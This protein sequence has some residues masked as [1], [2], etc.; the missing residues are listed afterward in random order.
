MAIDPICG[1]Q[2]DP[3]VAK[4]RYETPAGPVFFCSQGCLNRFREQQLGGQAEVAS[5]EV[6]LTKSCC[7]A[8]ADSAAEGTALPRGKPFPSLAV[9]QPTTPPPKAAPKTT[10]RFFCPCCPGVESKVPADCPKCGMPLQ[11]NPGYRE[12]TL[13]TCPMHPEIRR[14]EP[15]DCPICG[16]E[17][18][19]LTASVADTDSMGLRAMQRRFVGAA[20]GT[21]PL[22]VLA[23]GPMLGLSLGGLEHG[24]IGGWLQALLATPVVLWAGWPLWVRGWRSIVLGSPNMFTLIL[25]GTAAAFGLSWLVLLVPQWLPAAASGPHGSLYFE[26]A[27]VIVTLVLLGQVLEI[28]ARRRVQAAVGELLSLRPETARRLE[29][30]SEVEVPVERLRVGDRIRVL[31]GARIPTD[32]RVL[33][34][35]SFVDESMVTGEP[36][37]VRREPGMSVVGGT[38]NGDGP[39][40]LEV[41][42]ISTRSLLARIAAA[43]SEAQRTRAPIQSLADQVAGVFVPVVVAIALL[44]FLVWVLVGPPEM[45]W[46]GGFLAAVSVLLIACPCALGLATPVSIMVGMGRGARDGILIRDGETLERLAAVDVVAFDKTGTLTLGK[47]HL[48]AT[49]EVPSESGEALVA[50]ARLRQVA[51]AIESGS[52]HPLARAF[53]EGARSE[54]VVLPTASEIGIVPGQGVRGKV[55]GQLW[56]LGR[57]EW[58][59]GHGMVLP[60]ALREPMA[61]ATGSLVLLACDG[62]I[63]GGFEVGDE[64]K[65]ASAEA[66]SELKRMGIEPVL[67]T[68]DRRASA[69]RIARAVGIERVFAEVDPEGKL[70]E[71]RSLKEAGRKVAMIG[72]GINDAPALAAADVGIAMGTGTDVAIESAG[73]SLI[74][75]DPRSVARAIRISRRVMT[76]IRQNLFFAFVYNAA[77]IPIAAGVLYPWFGMLLSPMWAAAAMSFSSLSVIGNALRLRR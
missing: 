52:E 50:E 26:S 12:A 57:P 14:D 23:M 40:I 59:T 21:V 32:S 47:P 76:N 68:G 73:V 10:A 34:G 48:E 56:E 27:A 6:P 65:P 51:A 62:K 8:G 13:Y 41:R 63:V 66:V 58:L 44:A 46:T 16:M 74:A 4:W 24:A 36:L 72:D 75:G 61:R 77:G 29:G 19:P 37:P 18:E 43:V 60:E 28:V 25:L 39:L 5:P 17:L 53:V 69:E 64:L 38:L 54:H 49:W 55:E 45:R 15:G 2:V 20:I 42:E 9:L 67:L 22:L 71:V 3:S 1:M 30:D 33:E 31:P 7:H 35:A 70:R 11:P